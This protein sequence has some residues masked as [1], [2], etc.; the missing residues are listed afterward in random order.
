MVIIFNH[1]GVYQTLSL[2]IFVFRYFQVYAFMRQNI[3]VAPKGSILDLICTEIL[4]IL[5]IY[6][7]G[8]KLAFKYLI[9]K[10]TR[11]GGAHLESQLCG[12]LR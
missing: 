6:V 10:L 3:L 8:Q 7:F 9:Q 11:R 4:M 1:R 5:K 12:R 2:N